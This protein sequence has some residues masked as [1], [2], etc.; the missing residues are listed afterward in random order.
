MDVDSL[1]QDLPEWDSSSIRPASF[2][3]ELFAGVP[4][5]V[6]GCSGLFASSNESLSSENYLFVTDL[7]ERGF[8]KVNGEMVRLEREGYKLAEGAIIETYSGAGFRV[9]VDVRRE[10]QLGEELWLYIGTV[11]VIRGREQQVLR[12]SGEVGC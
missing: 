6:D 3:T 10:A 9:E 2:T 5:E 1:F 12:V 8:L 11:R 4:K 7:Q